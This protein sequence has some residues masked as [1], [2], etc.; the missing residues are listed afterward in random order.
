MTHVLIRKGT[1]GG[2][3]TGREWNVKTEAETGTICLTKPRK[4]QDCQQPPVRR[5]VRDCLSLRPWVPNRFGIRDRFH[6]RH[7]PQTKMGMG[8]M[9]AG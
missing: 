9:V 4:A 6:G 7:F 5:E 1:F 8:G 3:F 2:D